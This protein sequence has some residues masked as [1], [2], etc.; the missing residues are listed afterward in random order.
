MMRR[1][2]V[3]VMVAGLVA[4]GASAC[5]DSEADED[6]DRVTRIDGPAVVDREDSG[7]TQS[8]NDDE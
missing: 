6:R 2:W 7:V 5:S 4:V 8:G 3:I 1:V